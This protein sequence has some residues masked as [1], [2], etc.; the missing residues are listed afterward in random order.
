MATEL[1]AA[2][3]ASATPASSSAL[4]SEQEPPSPPSSLQAL[5]L[6]RVTCERFM[7]RR[8]T[9]RSGVNR[10]YRPSFVREMNARQL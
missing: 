1:S 10:F 3:D 7:R 5:D 4:V 2:A 9:D 8:R 6:V